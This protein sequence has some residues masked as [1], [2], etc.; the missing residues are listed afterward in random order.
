MRMSILKSRTHIQDARK[1]AEKFNAKL[2]EARRDQADI[3][4]ITAE[5]SKVQDKDVAEAMQSA[6]R[7]KRDVGATLRA[8][9]ETVT[10]F[11]KMII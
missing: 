4:S 1:E 9:E 3:N 7:R 8:L 5:L 10:M 6:E 11:K 2:T